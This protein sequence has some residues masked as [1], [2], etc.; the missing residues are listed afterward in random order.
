MLFT[1]RSDIIF[2]PIKRSLS[3][4]II[5]KERLIKTRL[6]N[7]LPQV[8]LDSLIRIT[9]EAPDD[10]TENG[11]EYFVDELERLNPKLKID[12]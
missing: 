1:A 7:Q 6:H 12:L 2:I 3:G 9:K 10:F 8:T 5:F 4:K 11:F